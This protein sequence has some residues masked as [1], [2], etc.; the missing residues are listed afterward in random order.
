MKA[1]D[2]LVAAR[3]LI[4]K[5]ENWAKHRFGLDE[6]ASCAMG[7]IHRAARE[8]NMNTAECRFFLE[9]AAKT[10]PYGLEDWND[11]RRRTH[12]QVLSA[13]DRAIELADKE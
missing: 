11:A 2:V 9:R 13:F 5:P 7:A 4:E 1:K 12:K 10:F 8:L 6:G 3:K